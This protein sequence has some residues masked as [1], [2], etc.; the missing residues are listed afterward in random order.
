MKK[1]RAGRIAVAIATVCLVLSIAGAASPAGN[2][3]LLPPHN[4]PSNWRSASHRYF[5]F[6]PVYNYVTMINLARK[7]QEGL[8]PLRFNLERYARLSIAQQ[9]FVLVNLERVSRGEVPSYG[10]YA[11]LNRT[12]AIG[13]RLGR[14][15][16]PVS[17]YGDF[18]SIWADAPNTRSQVSAFAIFDWMYEDGGP[19]YYGSV[20]GDCPRRGLPG[21]WGHRDAILEA[22]PD[23]IPEGFTLE[24]LTGAAGGVD[25]YHGVS[26]LAMAFT[27]SDGVPRTGIT[28]TWAQAVKY[29]DLPA[30][31]VPTST[32]APSTT[33]VPSTT[34]TVQSTTTTTG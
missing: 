24:L 22:T 13:A 31:D 21:C 15:P 7:S 1:I 19:P 30:S 18:E 4:P 9:L 26:S 11:P 10:L 2:R 20:N 23:V 12:S 34:T 32:T 27:W 6:Y 8:D 14:D 33:T 5:G 28:Y 25:N 29:L 3:V 17:K 16:S